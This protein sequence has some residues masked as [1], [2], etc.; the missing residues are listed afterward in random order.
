MDS[1]EL[2]NVRRVKRLGDLRHKIK[3]LEQHHKSLPDFKISQIQL[4]KS[5]QIDSEHTS[6]MTSN[7][8]KHEIRESCEDSLRLYKKNLQ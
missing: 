8:S 7:K 6:D 5:E 3:M 1:F 4:E 2:V